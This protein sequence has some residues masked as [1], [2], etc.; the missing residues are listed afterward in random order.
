MT[1]TWDLTAAPSRHWTLAPIPKRKPRS[2]T[3]GLTP[4]AKPRRAPKIGAR[5][6]V[7][8]RDF[9]VIIGGK[10]ERII[11][12]ISYISAGHQIVRKHPERFRPSSQ[13]RHLIRDLRNGEIRGTTQ[14]FGNGR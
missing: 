5:M 10:R 6:M 2:N 4:P 12:G 7:A 9:D 13:R 1:P 14:S 8:T 11:A 3:H